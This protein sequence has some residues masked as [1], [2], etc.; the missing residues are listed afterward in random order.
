M[1]P[2]GQTKLGFFPLPI[3]E[4]KRLRN[5]LNFPA[6][7]SAVDPC[8]GNGDAFLTLLGGKKVHGYGVEY[9]LAIVAKGHRRGR[10]SRATDCTI[11]L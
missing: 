9:A 6:E 4:A 1:R 10:K 8:V 2:Q 5:W 7:Y 3:T 11:V